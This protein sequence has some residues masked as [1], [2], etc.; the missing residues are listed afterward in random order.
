MGFPFCYSP[1]VLLSS[2]RS[3]PLETPFAARTSSQRRFLWTT[4]VVSPASR[5]WYRCGPCCPALTT[6]GPPPGRPRAGAEVTEDQ[7]F[8]PRQAQRFKGQSCS[9][10]NDVGNKGRRAMKCP[11]R[12]Q[13]TDSSPK[14]AG[15]FP[16]ELSCLSGST[17][18]GPPVIP[19]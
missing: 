15:T 16:S 5:H 7:T 1:H 10:E 13:R 6:D 9:G 4:H 18:R 12:L 14:Q 11:H 3:H 2:R 8:Q 19:A 17:L